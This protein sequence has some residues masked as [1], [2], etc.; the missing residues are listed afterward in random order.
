[1]R[2]QRSRQRGAAALEFALVA[3]VIILMVFGM[4]DFAMV[5]NA[6]AVVANAARDAARAASLNANELSAHR[7]A[8][9]TASNLNRA[10][11]DTNPTVRVDCILADLATACTGANYDAAVKPPDSVVRVTV[12]YRYTYITPLPGLIGMGGQTTMTKQSFM[13]IEAAR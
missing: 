1:M 6:Q 13:R 2:V 8:W 7:A 9:V 10:A 11:Y 5:M 3:P 4:I 12:T